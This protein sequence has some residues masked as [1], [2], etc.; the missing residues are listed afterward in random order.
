MLTGFRGSLVRCADNP[1]PPLFCGS[2]TG[3]IS[4]EFLAGR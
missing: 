1:L 4:K 3:W 2:L